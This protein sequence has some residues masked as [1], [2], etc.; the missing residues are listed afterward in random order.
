[1]IPAQTGLRDL[2]RAP[3]RR[4][5]RRVARRAWGANHVNAVLDTSILVDYLNE[6]PGAAQ[7]IDRYDQ[8]AISVVSWI[9]VMVGTRP[10]EEEAVVRGFLATFELNHVDQQ[11][12]ERA[13]RIRRSRR[14]RVP[15]AIIEATARVRGELL[16]TRT[17]RDLPRDDPG[18]RIPPYQVSATG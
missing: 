8:L 7:E 6:V 13:T 18:I 4:A 11:I 14:I 12:A 16:V 1:M 3:C 5:P 10:G 2:A 15:D 9:E 17:T